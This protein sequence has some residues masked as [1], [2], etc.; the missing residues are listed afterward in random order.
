MTSIRCPGFF[1][2]DVLNTKHPAVNALW[3]IESWEAW[4]ARHA[5]GD[6]QE[7]LI[8]TAEFY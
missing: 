2:P 1:T 7:K 8:K 3:T 4:D 6:A 5:A